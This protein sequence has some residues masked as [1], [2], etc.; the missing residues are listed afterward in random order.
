MARTPKWRAV[1]TRKVYLGA[2]GIESR[3]AQ[4]TF[5]AR[6]EPRR[7]GRFPPHRDDKILVGPLGRP[8]VDGNDLA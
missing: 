4:L 2:S 5:E 3:N 7:T 1:A 6:K 8:E